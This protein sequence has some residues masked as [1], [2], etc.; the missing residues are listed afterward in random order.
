MAFQYAQLKPDFIRIVEIVPGQSHEPINITLT[1]TRL[2]AAPAFEA[3]SYTWGDPNIKTQIYCQG[4][5]L[6]I[7]TNLHHALVNFRLA[8]RSRLVWADAI[9]I[10]Q[11]DLTEKAHQL[12][13][14]H[15]VYSSATKVLVWLGPPDAH[16][17]VAMDTLGQ[18]GAAFAQDLSIQEDQL[19]WHV[20]NRGRDPVQARKV[21]FKG[22][23]SP[24]SLNWISLFHLLNRPWFQRIWVIQEIYFSRK[25]EFYCGARHTSLAPLYYAQ[26]WIITNQYSLDVAMLRDHHAAFTGASANLLIMLDDKQA[27]RKDN[28]Q[29]DSLL[30]SGLRFK[31]TDPKDMVYALMNVPVFIRDCPGLVPDYRLPLWEIYADVAQKVVETT[32]SLKILTRIGMWQC[33]LPRSDNFPSWVPQWHS[34]R[35]GGSMGGVIWDH[36]AAGSVGISNVSFPALGVLQVEGIGFDTIVDVCKVHLFRSGGQL[37]QADT[38]WARYSETGQ[39]YPTKEDIITAYAMTLA[40]GC[41]EHKGALGMKAEEDYMGDMRANFTAWLE[42]QRDKAATLQVPPSTSYYPP[43]MYSD[44]MPILPE[45]PKTAKGS[46]AHIYSTT[47]AAAIAGARS[48][49]RTKRGYLGL[50]STDPKVGD[51][52]CLIPGAHLPFVLRPRI[53]DGDYWFIGD[54]Y[55]HGIMDGQGLSMG[56]TGPAQLFNIY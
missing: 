34:D 43:G 26:D 30:A 32:K 18:I 51:V 22:L 20:I 16:T 8:D 19:D 14:I 9:C 5:T 25:H 42:Q 28:I 29:V 56:Q 12:R 35:A 44:D 23:P 39:P 54:A 31:A 10:N 17:D 2:T 7:T 55:V 38:S 37:F 15:R 40:C 24:D 50:G 13:L 4:K 41:R 49:F 6:Q 53:P 46:I 52:V 3:L 33:G 11:T 1:E 27:G 47:V 48:L 36:F 21:G 45:M